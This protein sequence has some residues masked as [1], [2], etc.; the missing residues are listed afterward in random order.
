MAAAK[1][2]M[3]VEQGTTWNKTFTWKVK[4]NAGNFQPVN[5]TGY[6][7]RMH[8]RRRITDA[9][10][11]VALTTANSAIILGGA[12]GTITLSLDAAATAAL[13][14]GPWVY[15]LEVINPSGVVERLLKGTFLVDPEVTR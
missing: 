12:A 14:A 1:Y 11:I 10:F 6:T 13:P 5:I 15:D 8:V 3:L 4:D 7:A 2:K 9:N